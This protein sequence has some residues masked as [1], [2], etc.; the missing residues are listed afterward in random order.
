MSIKSIDHVILCHG[1]AQNI[2][3]Y[4]EPPVCSGLVRTIFGS[5][6]ANSGPTSQLVACPLSGL[7]YWTLAYSRSNH[8]F[9]DQNDPRSLVW[10]SSIY[11]D[12]RL[13]TGKS[14]GSRLS[15]GSCF[16]CHINIS[17]THLSFSVLLTLHF[18]LVLSLLL[19]ACYLP[20]GTCSSPLWPREEL[21][22]GQRG[23]WPSEPW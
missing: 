2:W 13:V 23:P 20:T 17:S 6:S 8:L 3:G 18:T 9:S 12:W 1:H 14:C 16:W 7:C 22:W 21:H 10:L 15:S 11:L 19:S 4:V 5:C